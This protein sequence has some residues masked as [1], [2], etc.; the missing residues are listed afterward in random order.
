MEDN[1][2]KMTEAEVVAEEVNQPEAEAAAEADGG[3]SADKKED[4][5]FFTKKKSGGETKKLKE[6]LAA[7]QKQVEE[8]QNRY[9]RLAAEYD[10][11]KKRTAR[12]LDARYADA[13]SDVLKTILPVIDNFE[14][15]LAMETEDAA[16]KEGVE[17]IFKQFLDLLNQ[18]G[19]TEIEAQGKVFDPELHNA[20]MHVEDENAGENEIVEVFMKGYK[21]GDKVLRHSMVKVAN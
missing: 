19:V 8:M 11:Y 3:N 18:H 7:L 16:Y 6:E 17:L 4:K 21:Q 13:K 12:E 10:N 14:R 1:K 2:E 5:S 20:V 15:G 9:V